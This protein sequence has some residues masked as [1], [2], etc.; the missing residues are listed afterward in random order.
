[1][2][3]F[4]SR[5]LPRAAARG[6]VPQGLCLWHRWCQLPDRQP[7]LCWPHVHDW[8]SPCCCAWCC[9]QMPICWYQGELFQQKKISLF[10]TVFYVKG[11]FRS[12]LKNTW[13][14]VVFAVRVVRS[15]WS[16]E[17]TQ[18][19]PRPLPRVWASSQ[20]ATR[21]WKTLQLASTYLSARWT[22]GKEYSREKHTHNRPTAYEVI[23]TSMF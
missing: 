4:P 14:N 6:P 2:F 7:L 8:S 19:Q 23:N 11:L 21:Q 13:W 10:L 1:M 3:P 12:T 15:S 9:W 20:K 22:P 16:L 18:S 17:I 5:F